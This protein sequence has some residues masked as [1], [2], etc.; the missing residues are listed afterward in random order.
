[1]KCPRC[2]IDLVGYHSTEYD[3]VDALLVELAKA[4]A[5][6]DMLDAHLIKRTDELDSERTRT[7]LLNEWLAARTIEWE[8]AIDDLA[9][10]KAEAERVM[11]LVVTAAQVRAAIH[12]MERDK[13][14]NSDGCEVSPSP[15]CGCICDRCVIGHNT[16]SPAEHTCRCRAAMEERTAEVKP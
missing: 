8:N 7:G 1:M 14:R 15:C 2:K 6:A 10:V 11:A 12:E 5:H 3:C 13:L 9:T 4:R 16:G